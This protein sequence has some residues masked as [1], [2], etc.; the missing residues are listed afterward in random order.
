VA[1]ASYCSWQ[2]VSQA[3]NTFHVGVLY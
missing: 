1:I 2:Y 3:G